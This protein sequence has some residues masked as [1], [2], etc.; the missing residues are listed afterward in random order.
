[1]GLLQRVV[2]GKFSNSTSSKAFATNGGLLAK[3]E[4][5]SEK[6]SNSSFQQWAIDSKFEHC[7]L[8]IQS[9]SLVLLNYAFGLDTNTIGS[10][11][12]SKDFWDGTIESDKWNTYKSSEKSFNNFVQFL[13]KKNRNLITHISLLKFCISN[14]MY[15]LM[16]LSEKKMSDLPTVEQTK[17]EIKSILN[18]TY[19]KKSF[20]SIANGFS[21]SKANLFILPLEDIIKNSFESFKIKNKL[22]L[23]TISICF[24]NEIL[25]ELQQAF[26]FPNCIV[27][28]D[29]KEIRIVFFSKQEDYEILQNHILNT[30]KKYLEDT[31]N[32]DSII[33]LP[34]GESVKTT[35]ITDFLLQG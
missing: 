34:A 4:Q 13:S 2:E 30:I 6:K 21:I 17:D 26:P 11:V 28:I 22:I 12:S 29:L 10:C 16:V 24:F 5:F 1:M 20:E 9:D 14:C 23:N 15:V 35:Q 25:F 31:I 33:L 3:A 19:E 7:G 18:F 32:T 27:G 8:F